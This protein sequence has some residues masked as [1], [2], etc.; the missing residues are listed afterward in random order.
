MSRKDKMTKKLFSEMILNLICMLNLFVDLVGL[1]MLLHIVVI[2]EVLIQNKLQEFLLLIMQIVLW[3]LFFMKLLPCQPIQQITSKFIKSDMLVMILCTSFILKIPVIMLQLPS[4]VN[5]MMPMLLFIL[6]QM[7][8]SVF[9]YIER[10]MSKYLV[11][12]F[13]VCALIRNCLLH[14]YGKLQSMP[15][16]MF[17]IILVDTMSDTPAPSQQG[18]ELL[19]KLLNVLR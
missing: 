17:V 10:K 4:Q 18:E 14:L 12:W 15:I 3:K 9:K 8:C 16:D 6:C 1:L 5:L 13:T 19:M 7:V 2:L 11:L